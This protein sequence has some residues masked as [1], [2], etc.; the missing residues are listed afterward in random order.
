MA[1]HYSTSK[2]SPIF[3]HL[4]AQPAPSWVAL[5]SHRNPLRFGFFC[6]F[7]DSLLHVEKLK[8]RGS[9]EQELRKAG[10]RSGEV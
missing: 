7:T 8:N 10:C 2:S 5:A 6:I 4:S 3:H 1:P 9:P